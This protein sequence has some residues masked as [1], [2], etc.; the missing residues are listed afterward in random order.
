[1]PLV[2]ARDF[3]IGHPPVLRET[4]TTTG[5]GDALVGL[6]YGLHQGPAGSLVATVGVE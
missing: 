1:M 6:R 5:N 4:F 3:D 2:A